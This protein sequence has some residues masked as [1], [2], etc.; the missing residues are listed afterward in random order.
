MV[1]NCMRGGDFREGIRALLVDRDNSPKWDPST[2]T[3]VTEDRVK[4]FF[5]PLGDYDLD[6]F[7]QSG[8][9]DSRGAE[10]GEK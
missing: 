9:L 2:L 10:N 1:M 4:S 5:E 7:S 6:V 8:T 3:G